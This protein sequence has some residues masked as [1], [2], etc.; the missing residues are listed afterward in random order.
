[1][2]LNVRTA[3]GLVAGIAL[4]TAG[5]VW[6]T[7]DQAAPSLPA[8]PTLPD[9]AGAAAEVAAEDPAATDGEVGLS[10]VA[11]TGGHSIIVQTGDHSPVTIT[12]GAEGPEV[13]TQGGDP[14]HEDPGAVSVD[15]LEEEALAG[16]HAAP[17]G[18]PVAAPN[19]VAPLMEHE[20][21]SLSPYELAQTIHVCYG[22]NLSASGGMVV[23]RSLRDCIDLLHEDM[24]A[25]THAAVDAVG[26]E[27]WLQLPPAQQGVLA[28]L[29]Y[30]VGA[31]GIQG[32]RNFLEA[33][34]DRDWF[35]AA[36]ELQT[37]MLPFQISP[38]RLSD[39]VTRVQR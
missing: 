10:A 20:G 13:E 22:H 9:L 8:I 26:E 25:A 30:L 14:E 27:T 28:E 24:R 39:M 34:R 18:G 2:H 5:A 36:I 17:D 4:A 37:S 6:S 33:L 11:G 19:P 23:D 32:F 31:G 35:R 1:M 3:Y 16:G 15:P 21:L 7:S 29:S 38:D 12:I